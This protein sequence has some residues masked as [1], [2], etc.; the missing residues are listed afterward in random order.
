MIEGL[1]NYLESKRRDR[2]RRE[3]PKGFSKWFITN[4]GEDKQGWMRVYNS[5]YSM[6]FEP[7]KQLVFQHKDSLYKI[8]EDDEGNLNYL[9]F[10]WDIPEEAKSVCE[11][12]T[13]VD[14]MGE[15]KFDV[16]R[17]SAWVRC[18]KMLDEIEDKYTIDEAND[19]ISRE[20]VGQK[21]EVMTHIENGDVTNQFY[22]LF[23][24]N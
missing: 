18:T 13:S 21:D 20:L 3:L 7:Y 10:K 4:V 6:S 5:T 16:Q 19:W 14:F 9:P 12:F 24:T 17:Y 22:N 11:N 23:M 8:L 1:D 15:P 2:T